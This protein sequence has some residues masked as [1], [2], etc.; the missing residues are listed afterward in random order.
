MDNKQGDDF[1]KKSGTHFI[2]KG[3]VGDHK[4]HMSPQMIERFDKWIEENT[5]GTDL[6]F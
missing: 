2:R 3:I 5:K 4:N 6:K 1:Y